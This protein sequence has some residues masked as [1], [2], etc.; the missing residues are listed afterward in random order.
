MKRLL[1]LLSALSLVACLDVT[2]PG[3]SNPAFETFAPSLGVDLADPAWKQTA[4]GTY[5][6]DEV[7]GTGASLV[8]PD[9]NDSVF[10]DYTGYL[11][12]GTSFTAGPHTDEHLLAAGVI[13]GFIDGMTDMRVGGQRLVVVPSNLGY[14]NST[15]GRIPP[16]STLVFRIKL[17]GFF[18]N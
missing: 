11:K 17:N 14:G 12:D 2:G 15:N 16:N 3:G 4:Q 7:V 9:P 18:N 8:L 5:Y 1:V 10:V 6:K 13:V